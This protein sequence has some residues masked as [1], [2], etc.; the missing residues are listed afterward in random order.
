MNT[1]ALCIAATLL[2]SASL[3]S[4]AQESQLSAIEIKSGSTFPARDTLDCGSES[5]PDASACLEGLKW[6]CAPFEVQC[7]PARQ[8][9]GDW[10]MRF[11]TPLP[12]GDSTND[13]VA[14]EWYQARD[15]KGEPVRAPAVVVVHESGRGMV[16]GRI[17]A[18]G[19]QSHGFHTFLIHLPGYGARTSAFT[20][21][22]KRMLPG[23]KQA[24]GD[25]RRARDAVASLPYIDRAHIS[26]QG[27]SLGGFVSATVAG[28]DRGFEKSFILLAGGN[29]AEVLL[30]GERDA[31]AMHRDLAAAGITDQQI[32][33]LSQV[34]EPMR[35]AHRV[36][37]ENTWLFSG[38]LDEVVPPDCSLAFAKAAQLRPDHHFELPVGHYTAAIL[39]PT[40]LGNI[41]DLLKGRPM[42]NPPPGTGTAPSEK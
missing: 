3:P 39:L 28:L 19:L 2:L 36:A 23:L 15:A 35:L 26:L 13:L 5:R 38:K 1:P 17:F 25:V 6:A 34:I 7:Q 9:L 29:L 37:S 4:I 27:T 31:A 16:A 42:S 22:V 20:G 40:I 18:K 21:D 14:M 32:R 12:S 24:I 10:L 30:H 41:S 8:G 33:D 11:P